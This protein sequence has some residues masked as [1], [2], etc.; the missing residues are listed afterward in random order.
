MR[1]LFF[2]ISIFIFLKTV[3]YGI[4]EFKNNK[5][6][7]GGTLITILAFVTIVFFNIMAFIR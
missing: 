4:Y 3:S 2:I 1:I 6:K 5:N 7:F